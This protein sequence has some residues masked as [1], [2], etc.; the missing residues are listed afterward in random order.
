MTGGGWF[1]CPAA[2]WPVVV[3]QLEKLGEPWPDEMIAIDLAWWADQVDLGKRR[4]PG[5]PTLA[6]R[7]RVTDW[8]AKRALRTLS[9]PAAASRPPADRQPTASAATDK[10]C[11][12][13]DNHQPTTSRPPA[14]RPARVYNR[15]TDTDTDDQ[16][17]PATAAPPV[18]A[19][20]GKRS[21]RPPPPASSAHEPFE[22]AVSLYRCVWPRSRVTRSTRHGKALAGLLRRYGSEDV[23][24][25]FRWYA[26]A[27]DSRARQL[28][29]VE[30]WP[31]GRKTKRGIDTIR[32]RFETYLELADEWESPTLLDAHQV[33]IDGASAWADI[34]SRS[35]WIRPD[36]GP[37]R[38]FGEPGRWYLATDQA[39]H[40]RRYAA[41]AAVGG[42][43][44]R[45]QLPAGHRGALD[46]FKRAWIAAYERHAAQRRVAA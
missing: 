24:R 13:G 17:A 4:R 16:E 41:L 5:R 29:G 46:S 44:A 43:P 42:W 18:E 45:C 1:R 32:T 3:E 35:E 37:A 12:S 14:D 36:R 7:W 19:S 2:S 20:N 9:P 11:T 28:R 26:T 33:G 31:D 39:E 22:Q 25:V 21:Q 30:P 38:V 10:P 34:A 6:C 15:Q 40:D 27:N 8:H 23:L